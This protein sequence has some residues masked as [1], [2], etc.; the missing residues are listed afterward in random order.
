M[1]CC[2]WVHCKGDCSLCGTGCRKGACFYRCKN[3][4]LSWFV[5]LMVTMEPKLRKLIA[6]CS[7]VLFLVSLATNEAVADA[8]SRRYVSVEDLTYDLRTRNVDLI[9]E[10]MNDI[11]RMRNKGQILP[12]LLALWN[13]ERDAYPKI[14]WSIVTA[15]RVKI[16]I[17]EILMQAEKNNFI[18]VDKEPFRNYARSIITSQD[19]FIVWGAIQVLGTVD[20]ARDVE[21]IV[22]TAEKRNNRGIFRLAI[23]ALASM[24]GEAA[25]AGLS[26]LDRGITDP[27]EKEFVN[28]VAPKYRELRDQARWCS[29]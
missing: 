9:V 15:D 16:E 11:K 12:F 6:L 29:R 10:T 19:V 8:E 3:A 27:E 7:C 26:R 20:D 4:S 2:S 25:A 28:E 14:P 18:E 5:A 21:V 1:T 22:N 23:I 24:C 13:E 17:A